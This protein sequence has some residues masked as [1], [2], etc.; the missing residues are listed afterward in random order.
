LV[1]ESLRVKEM[2]ECWDVAREVICWGSPKI[3]T[4]LFCGEFAFG[5]LFSRSFFCWQKQTSKAIIHAPTFMHQHSI[6]SR[7]SSIIIIQIDNAVLSTKNCVF[8][9]NAT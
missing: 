9:S 2:I 1:S 6:A 7:R 4:D 5:V 3:R 8:K